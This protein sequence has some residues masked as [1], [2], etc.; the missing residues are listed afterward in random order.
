MTKTVEANEENKTEAP[1]KKKKRSG[2]KTA[3]PEMAFNIDAPVFAPS[4]E[5]AS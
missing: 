4:V 3:K 2:K 1:K 5:P